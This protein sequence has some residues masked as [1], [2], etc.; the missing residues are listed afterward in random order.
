MTKVTLKGNAI[1]T[2]GSLPSIGT[3]TPDFKLVKTD[4]SVVSLANFSGK[5]LII[6]IFPSIDTDVCAAAARQFN[7]EISGQ[8]NVVVLCVSMD[9]PFAHKRFCEAEG[10]N[11]IVT[12]S[13]FR[14]HQFGND[15]GIRLVDG[16]LQG[17]LARAIV[18]TDAQHKVIYTELVPEITQEPDYEAAMFQVL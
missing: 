2:V 7:E 6:N 12:A 8:S 11:H 1:N 13:A 16:P 9:L 4:L 3:K 10:L 15:Y 5:Q 17:L 14:E 18:I